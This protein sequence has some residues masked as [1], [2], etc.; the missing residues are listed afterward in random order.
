MRVG[1]MITVR[2]C[3]RLFEPMVFMRIS[4]ACRPMV[5]LPWSMVESG[6]RSRSE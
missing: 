4:A 6:T 3:R 2:G 1:S 5:V